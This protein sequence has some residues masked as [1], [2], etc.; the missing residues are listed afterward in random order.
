M[1][2]KL[3]TKAIT[4][5]AITADKIVAGAVVADIGAGTVTPTHLHS[6]LDLSG[7]TITLPSLTDIGIGTASPAKKLHIKDAIPDIRLE[8][9]DTN[10]VS[11][12]RGNTGTGSFVLATDVNNAVA[13]SKIIFQVDDDEK[14]RIDHSGNVLVGQTSSTAP[15]SSN[16]VTGCTLDGANGIVYGSRGSGASGIF[17]A[18]ADGE[19]VRYH[20][21]G[22][23]VGSITVDSSSATYNTTSDG[24]L[25]ENIEPINDG[26]EKLMA[27]N[28]VTF[29]WKN[30]PDK[31]TQQGFI[32]QDMQ[33][34]SP[35][36]V[37]ILDGKDM[38]GMDY[39]RITPIL[40]AALQNALKRIQELEEK[41]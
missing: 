2:R 33:H 24:R 10:A 27:M 34:I 5:D 19:L 1:A 13:N 29:T 14:V 22:T 11:E 9:T 17:N 40:V 39:G 35:E 12:L 8:D 23:L 16:T 15:G 36:S 6:T 7:K 20:R 21:S 25:K 28:P 30:D 32:A 38:L 4:D 31:K 3:T 26:L 18:N 41:K 37:N